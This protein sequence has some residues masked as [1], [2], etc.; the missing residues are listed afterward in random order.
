MTPC[1]Y[2]LTKGRKKKT[3]PLVDFA[4]GFTGPLVDPNGTLALQ[5][6]R[7]QMAT[8]AASYM[9]GHNAMGGNV[10]R[11]LKNKQTKENKK[12]EEWRSP[13][14]RHVQ[15]TLEEKSG[16]W[17]LCLHTGGDCIL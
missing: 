14:S 17:E 9:S 3:F 5:E 4:I 10:R 6:A 2:F 15:T 13:K 8:A 16:R 1:R 7:D 11:P 12:T